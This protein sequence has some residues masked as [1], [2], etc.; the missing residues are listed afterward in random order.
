MLV[1]LWLGVSLATVLVFARHLGTLLQPA[2]AAVT[3][4]S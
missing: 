4:A 1:T 2:A 3:I